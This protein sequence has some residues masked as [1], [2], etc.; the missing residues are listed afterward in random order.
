MRNT[1]SCIRVV[2]AYEHPDRVIPGKS[3]AQ[4][5]GEVAIGALT[6]AGLQLAD[7]D[8]YCCAGDAPGLGPV[9]MA[10]YLGLKNVTYFDSTD[11]GGSAPVAHLGHAAAAIAAG[12]CRV[13]LITLAGLPR[14][15]A[16][17][18]TIWE[19]PEAPFETVYGTTTPALYA[20]AAQRHMYDYGTTSAQLAEIKVAA[21]L[22]AQHNPHAFMQKPVTVEEVLDSPWVSEPLHRLDC[23]I[24]TDGGG[25]LVVAAPE[26]A[27]DLSRR[28]AVLL[29]HGE[30]LK[31]SSD[32]RIDL[33]Y[34]GAVRSGPQ[35]FEQAGVTPAD[36]DYASIYDSFTITVLMTLEDLG[37]CEKG[38]GG[39]F[40]SDGGLLSPGGRLPFNT[41]GGGLCNNHPANRG[42][43]TK[44]IEAVRQL[45]GEAHPAVQVPNCEIALVH[46]TGGTL[47]SRMGSV[48]AILGAEE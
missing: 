43:V 38:K 25:A 3:V 21:S 30:A 14:S 37:F 4:V 15:T 11:V 12:K 18:R 19:A 46:G 44:I 24:V 41:D 29:G 47:G 26:V 48:T 34:T 10:Q 17:V 2:G 35:A 42:G 9:S 39:V 33:S 13:V 16:S 45:R 36:I 6:D 7:V 22:H 20:L 8:G 32:G 1:K 27:K 28:G 5:H 31:H 23:C 40:V